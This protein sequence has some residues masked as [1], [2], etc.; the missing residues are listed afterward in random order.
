MAFGM[1]IVSTA[2]A[3]KLH[4]TILFGLTGDVKSAKLLQAVEAIWASVNGPQHI[5]SIS[6]LL[7]K[8]GLFPWCKLKIKVPAKPVWKV[9]QLGFGAEPKH[10]GEPKLGIPIKLGCGEIFP[11]QIGD[12]VAQVAC[13]YIKLMLKKVKNS[14]RNFFIFYV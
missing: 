6:V 5:K 10:P 12:I 7:Y 9:Y 8:G 2:A 4:A 13:E 1:V 11:E 3:E 14:K